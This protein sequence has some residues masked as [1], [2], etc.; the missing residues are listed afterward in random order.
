MLAHHGTTDGR[1][2][3]G[4]TIAD[5]EDPMRHQVH[6]WLSG[7]TY[8][9]RHRAW[10]GRAATLALSTTLLAGLASCGTPSAQLIYDNSNASKMRDAAVTFSGSNNAG[11][12]A[13]SISVTGDGEIVKTPAAFKL[14]MVLQLSS[15]QT[16]GSVAIDAIEVKS[17]DYVKINTSIGGRGS[18]GSAK[19]IVTDA[20]GDAT[21][22]TPRLSNL[23]L[24][25]EQ[26]IHGTKC[27][28]LTGDSKDAN[29]KVSTENLW[30][31]ESDYYPVREKLSTLPG[32]NLSAGAASSALHLSLTIDFSNYDTGAV[33]S[34]PDASQIG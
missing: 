6:P 14:H 24:A 5:E 8:T 9:C 34:A 15:A 3:I 31:R 16:S 32:V 23:K 13:S 25:G 28:H 27:W 19:Y 11:A 12:S 10:I 2:E 26:T 29:G 33:I 17:K 22:L 4:R 7:A 1:T 20:T 18:Y 21:A 30:V